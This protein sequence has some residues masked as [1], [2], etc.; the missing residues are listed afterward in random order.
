MYVLKVAYPPKL[1]SMKTKHGSALFTA[2]PP[3]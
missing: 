3:G 2:A 1:K